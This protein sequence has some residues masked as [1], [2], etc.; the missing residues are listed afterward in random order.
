MKALMILI[1]S[2]FSISLLA[3]NRPGS[4]VKRGKGPKI[5]PYK[6]NKQQKPVNAL[7]SQSIYLQGDYAAVME[8]L[9]KI[10]KENVISGD[11][12]DMEKDCKSDEICNSS[13]TLLEEQVKANKNN[14]PNL[15]ESAIRAIIDYLIPA[16]VLFMNHQARSNLSKYLFINADVSEEK[17]TD[18]D[19]RL[20]EVSNKA[21]HMMYKAPRQAYTVKASTDNNSIA[22]HRPKLSEVNF[23]LPLISYVVAKENCLNLK[24]LFPISNRNLLSK[25][26]K[27]NEKLSIK[28]NKCF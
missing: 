6:M 13:L 21:L 17:E 3:Q 20:I 26:L 8:L 14:E 2:I 23:N 28:I 12:E 10:S 7:S 27:E 11:Y 25:A 18:I 5:K 16:R 22:V 15:E 9:G 1:F 24:I 19:G 4:S